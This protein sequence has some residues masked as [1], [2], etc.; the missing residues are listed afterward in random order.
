MKKPGHGCTPN[1]PHSNLRY[2]SG[3]SQA[4]KGWVLMW[5]IEYVP[6]TGLGKRRVAARSESE[7]EARPAALILFERLA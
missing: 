7:S 4:R 2:H 1:E 3:Q 6:G 5:N